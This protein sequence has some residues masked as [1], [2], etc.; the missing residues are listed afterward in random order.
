MI[1]DEDVR[2][3]A[4]LTGDMNPVHLDDVQL[5]QGVGRHPRVRLP[6]W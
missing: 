2:L 4:R 1:S 3:F 6:A 5:L